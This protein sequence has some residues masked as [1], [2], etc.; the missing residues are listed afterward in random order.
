M[1]LLKSAAFWALA[2]AAMVLETAPA[3]ASEPGWSASDPL[4][5]PFEARLQQFAKGNLAANPSFEQTG[6]HAAEPDRDAAPP[7]WE[8][9][10]ARVEWIGQEAGASPAEIHHGRRAIRIQRPRA[11][12]PAPGA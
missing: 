8:R 11:G 10:G 1:R 6:G 9:V 3:G 5:I 12:E 2:L 4:S 7:G